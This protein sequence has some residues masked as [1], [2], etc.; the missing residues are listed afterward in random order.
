MKTLLLSALFLAA[1][2]YAGSALSFSEL[3]EACQDPA[4]FQ[5]QVAPQNIQVSCEERTT[6]WETD[7]GSSVELPRSKEIWSS[8]TSDKYESDTE[9]EKVGVKSQYGRC[10]RFKEVLEVLNFTKSTSCEEI[11]DFK[12]G[13]VDFCADVLERVR[14][15]NPKA[16]EKTA[17]GNTVDLCEEK[18]VEN[19]CDRAQRGQRGQGGDDGCGK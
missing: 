13:A 6:R 18:P 10:P 17:T 15:N 14:E 19:P 1:P 16:I 8:F 9:S 7:G 12:G 5:N 2:A 4:R 11:L 3:R